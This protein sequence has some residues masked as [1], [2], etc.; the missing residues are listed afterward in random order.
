M[1]FLVDANILSEATKDDPT[2]WV[3]DWLGQN[4][5]ELAVN[6]I[7]LGEL[8]FGI[9]SLPAGRRRARLTQWYS[10]GVNNLHVLVMDR[11]TAEVWATL[12]V[13]LK[14]QGR[15]MPI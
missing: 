9:L 11:H 13:D 5:V 3:M 12:A 7:I 1:K 10:Q 14:R 8:E 4:E 6:P 15:A 2:P